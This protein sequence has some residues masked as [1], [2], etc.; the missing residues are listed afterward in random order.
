M[1]IVVVYLLIEYNF[2]CAL[3]NQLYAAISHKL[4]CPTAILT[5]VY[6]NFSAV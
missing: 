3:I 6:V 2:Y 1:L 5:I 4:K